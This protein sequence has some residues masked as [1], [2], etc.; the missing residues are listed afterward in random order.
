[1]HKKD[2]CIKNVSYGFGF[3][4]VLAL[5]MLVHNDYILRIANMILI[6]MML[7]FGL[8]LITGYT[9]QLSLG[10]ASFYGIG[11]YT[12]A[13][14]TLRLGLPF[15][16]ALLSAGI[17]AC[18]FGI[19]LSI[20]TFRVDG[21]YLCI[22]TI[23]FAEIIRLIFLNWMDLTRGPMGLPGVPPVKIFGFVFMSNT[24]YYYLFLALATFTLFLM[25]RIVHS[26]IGRAFMSI[27]EDPI[28]ASAM[29]VNINYYKV[30]AFAIGAFFAGIA[31]S[32]FAHYLMF[33]GPTSFNVDA[34]LIVLQAVILGG[35]GSIPGVMIGTVIIVVL[36]ELFRTL[37]MYRMLWS[38]LLLVV[39][40]ILRPQ[41]I[42]GKASF[43][44]I[45]QHNKLFNRLKQKN[46]V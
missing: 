27:R 5:P 38:G 30:M 6:Y 10:H 44:Q 18:I 43:G 26:Q 1:L 8:N 24:S 28:A 25:V 20:P 2:F 22:V 11:A 3:V 41:G 36:P 39:L 45:V 23:G 35:M 4:A 33:V 34:S 14:L 19:L 31:G 13:L 15:P 16:L 46:H 9:G 37:Y 7:T 17:L 42:M 21:D 32:C 29:G 12:S 40:M